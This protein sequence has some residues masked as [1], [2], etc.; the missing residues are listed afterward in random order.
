MPNKRN[1]DV[2]EL[3][4]GRGAHLIGSLMDGLALVRTVPTSYGSDLHEMKKVLMYSLD[5]TTACLAVW[6]PFISALCFDGERA[7]ALCQQGHILATEIADAL[8][9]NGAAFRDA[10]RAVAML[11]QEAETQKIQV[12][13]LPLETVNQVLRA[14]NLPSRNDFRFDLKT[15]VERRNQPGGTAKKQVKSAIK[16]LRRYFAQA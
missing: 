16:A 15:A 13:E 5:E 11:V 4:R 6:P 9:E 12:H 3:T 1:P 14:H 7:Q 2:A 10:Y 8:V